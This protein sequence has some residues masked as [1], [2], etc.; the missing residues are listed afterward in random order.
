MLH[1]QYNLPLLVNTKNIQMYQIL[2][3]FFSSLSA[4]KL[5]REPPFGYARYSKSFSRVAVMY[6]RL[7]HNSNA[8][9]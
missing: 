9:T 1:H 6:V 4:I 2:I 3:L 8:C 7:I 5:I